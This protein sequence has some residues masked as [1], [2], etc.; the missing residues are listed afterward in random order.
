MDERKKLI[1]DSIDKAREVEEQVI[2][3]QKKFQE[4]IDEAKVEANKIAADAHESAK[5]MQEKMKVEAKEEIET[6]VLQAKKSI[7]SEK[8][9]MVASAKKEIATLVVSAVEKVLQE[10]LDTAGDQALVK[11]IVDSIK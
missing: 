8:E 9:E 10:K 4:K 2:L 1:D 11:K 6:L 3:S 7:Q 5:G